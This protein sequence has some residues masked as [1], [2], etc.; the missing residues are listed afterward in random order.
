[1]RSETRLSAIATSLILS[2]LALVVFGALW[3]VQCP[4]WLDRVHVPCALIVGVSFL[5][6]CP[7]LAVLG[8]L[9]SVRDLIRKGKRIQGLAALSIS[10]A[11]LAWYWL[12]PPL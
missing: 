11:L 2:S 3:F 6:V 10:V 9:F 7:T 4:A 8:L 5:A 12:N 1:M